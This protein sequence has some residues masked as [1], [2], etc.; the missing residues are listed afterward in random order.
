MNQ[1]SIA[2]L[3]QIARDTFGRELNTTQVKAYR[4]RLPVMVRAVQILQEWE[5]RLRDTE[6]AA[7]HRAPV[8]E[9]GEYGAV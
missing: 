7:V 6:P 3:Q 9:G 5:S 2:E 8:G 1:P 4:G